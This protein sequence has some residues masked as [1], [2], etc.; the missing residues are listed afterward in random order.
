MEIIWN[1]VK[2]VAL[3]GVFMA[4]LCVSDFIVDLVLAVFP[5]LAR[6]FDELPLN[7]R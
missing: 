2:L 3:M 7:R 4:V 6:W 1:I 5:G